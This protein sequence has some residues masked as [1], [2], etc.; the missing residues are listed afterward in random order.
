MIMKDNSHHIPM[1]QNDHFVH[2]EPVAC[3]LRCSAGLADEQVTRR[4][5]QFNPS[6]LLRTAA[7]WN[8]SD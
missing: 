3:T 1:E 5:K 8:K 7:A 4:Q 6:L 2:T